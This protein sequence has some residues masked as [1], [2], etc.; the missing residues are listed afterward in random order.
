MVT[1]KSRGRL[2]PMTLSK[3]YDD[4][5]W[6]EEYKS[7][8]NS[9]RELQLLEHGANSLAQ[10]WHLGSLYNNWKKIKGYDKLDPKEN[11]GQLQS[12]LQDF[13]KKQDNVSR[14]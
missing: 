7:Y 14:S 5:N 13:F 1:H 12:S 4:S 10:S 8:T 2:L 3:P 6:K 11:K 9:K